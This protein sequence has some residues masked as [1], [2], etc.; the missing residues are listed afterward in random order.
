MAGGLL[1][2]REGHGMKKTTKDKPKLTLDRETLVTL[3]RHE[4]AK[5]GGGLGDFGTT[6]GGGTVAGTLLTRNQCWA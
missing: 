3:E 6:G 5:V 2:S 4:V 1:W